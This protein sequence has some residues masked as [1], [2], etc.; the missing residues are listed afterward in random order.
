MWGTGYCYLIVEVD[1]GKRLKLDRGW[2]NEHFHCKLIDNE[3]D[4]CQVIEEFVPERE[5]TVEEVMRAAD[6]SVRKSYRLIYDNCFFFVGDVLEKGGAPR[7][8]VKA[9]FKSN[10][11]AVNNVLKNIGFVIKVA[12]LVGCLS[13]LIPQLWPFIQRPQPA[14]IPAQSS[15]V[16]ERPFTLQTKN[17]E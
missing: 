6:E 8:I 7:E 4:Q 11:S 1:S 14:P 3:G 15:N 17:W 5:L 9:I 12:V 10:R 13:Y 2:S 16:A